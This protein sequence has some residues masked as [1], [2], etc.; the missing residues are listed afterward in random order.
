V[1][2]AF[3]PP[4]GAW[5]SG[6]NSVYSVRILPNQV[7]D[8]DTPT[9]NAVEASIIGNFIVAISPFVV[10]EATDGS[11]TCRCERRYD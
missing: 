1:T 6:D 8:I 2:Y 11:I 3:T 10:D 5:N 4:G 7:F 9:A